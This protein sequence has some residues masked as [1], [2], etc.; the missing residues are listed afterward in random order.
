MKREAFENIPQEV[1]QQQGEEE[2]KRIT[3]YK[4][5]TEKLASVTDNLQ[6]LEC[7]DELL[8]LNPDFMTAWNARRQAL[9][10]IIIDEEGMKKELLFGVASIKANPKSYGAWYHRKWLLKLIQSQN[11]SFD[12]GTELKLCNK[13]LDLDSRNCNLYWIDFL[14]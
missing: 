11:V 12:V 4:A 2:A 14:F 10:T 1:L 9:L 6:V 5:L 8:L 3:H 7:T 13:L